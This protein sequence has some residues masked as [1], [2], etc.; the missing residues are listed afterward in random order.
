MRSVGL[1]TAVVVA[2]LRINAAPTAT[3]ATVALPTVDLGYA[4]HQ[5]TI[6]V[7]IRGLKAGIEVQLETIEIRES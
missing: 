3:S 4:V 5:A 1:L 2:A 6:N 7:S